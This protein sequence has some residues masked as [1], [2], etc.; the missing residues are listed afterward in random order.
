MHEVARDLVPHFDNPKEL[1]TELVRRTWLTNF[2][3]DQLLRGGAQDLKVGPYLLLERLGRG[4]MG[5][6]FKARHLLLNRI[7]ALKVIRKD[8]NDAGNNERRFL[9][10]IRATAK[11]AHPNIVVAHDA[12]CADGVHFFAMEYIEG[13]DLARLVHETGPLPVTRACEYIRLAA[14][15]LQH[16]FEH[17]LVHRDIKP[18][19]LILTAR[20]AQIKIVD[21]GLV[22]LNH[23]PDE[24]A[25]TAAESVI[26]TPDYLA[27]EQATN[28]RTVDI[29]ADLY[30]LGCTFYFLLIGQHPFPGGTAIEK[31]IKHLE[32]EPTPI[33]D[34][35]PE[36]PAAVVAVVQ[37][38]MAKKPDDRYERPIEVA[39]VLAAF[40]HSSAEPS[41]PATA[42]LAP[43]P[44]YPMGGEFSVGD[45]PTAARG[46]VP[47][48]AGPEANHQ[49]PGPPSSI[50]EEVSVA[51]PPNIALVQDP[52]AAAA[53]L[54]NLGPAIR[55][56]MDGGFSVGGPPT[57]APVPVL[58]PTAPGAKNPI[59]PPKPAP[60][61]THPPRQRRRFAAGILLVVAC[62][63]LG[64]W[65]PWEASQNAGRHPPVKNS[66]GMELVLIP[67]GEFTM[68]AE[69]SEVGQ[70]GDEKPPHQIVI[71]RSFYLAIHETT[72]GQF[73]AFVEATGYQTEA[74]KNGF[75]ALHWDAVTGT[76]KADTKCTWR[77]P[78][79]SQT[80][81]HPVVCVSRYD[82][83]AFCY[84][85]S[86]KEGKI[87]RLPTEAEWEYACRAGTRAPYATGL[88]LTARQANFNDF[89]TPAV[90]DSVTGGRMATRV[91]SFAPN[92]W[93][94]YDMHG[95]ASEWC[96]DHYSST[97]YRASPARD[98]I[99]PQ[100]GTQGVLRGGSWQSA[101]LDCRSARR[102]GAPSDASRNDTGFRVVREA[103]VR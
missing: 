6:V 54:R 43:A 27:P 20:G 60:A 38:L 59:D 21:M 56:P 40:C 22:R 18:S 23:G 8:T 19:N 76:W 82:A 49:A 7:V 41:A 32:A 44:R 55:S 47:T 74:E 37:R 48:P 58:A 33:R 64:L 75:G 50:A 10:E 88:T 28:S 4:G 103:G 80:E 69:S 65:R 12:G 79:W 51:E 42:T 61:P 26:G 30:S 85:L 57:A 90:G 89:G 3:M 70:H 2:Q 39:E 13:T 72:V 93:G 101:A 53:E 73:R 91:G 35:R 9:R 29:R 36:V 96:A 46:P 16:A 66:I 1:L 5:D 92:A 17:G 78:G 14:L 68:G 100:S 71:N 86:R 84:W 77:N 95:N 67:A 97:Y 81:G 99:G 63:G 24:A 31:V 34:L 94:L 83:L 11:L 52:T 45:A 87:Y 25:L 15:G 102:C 62:F 98:P